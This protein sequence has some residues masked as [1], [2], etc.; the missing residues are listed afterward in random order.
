MK[1]HETLK[2]DPFYGNY[3]YFQDNIKINLLPVFFDLPDLRAI[4]DKIDELLE[5]NQSE[6]I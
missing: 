1:C 4:S 6:H 5:I 2:L 3:A